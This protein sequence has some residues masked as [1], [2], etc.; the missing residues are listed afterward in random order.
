V[1]IK[2]SF[3]KNKD[4]IR[5]IFLFTYPKFVFRKTDELPLGN[6]P[7]F[8]F[9]YLAPEKFEMQLRYLF[10]NN[11]K[12]IN[13]ETLARILS[14]K[15]KPIE[16]AIVLTFDDGLKSLWTIAYP[17]LK[18]YEFTG[19]SYIIP[20][21]INNHQYFE[22]T[23][24]NV[25]SLNKNRD[26]SLCAW[27]EIIKMHESGVIDFQSHS[28]THGT[29]FIND[30]IVDFINPSFQPNFINNRFNPLL[31]NDSDVTSINVKWGLPIYK[32]ESNLAAEK[33]YIENN[34]VQQICTQFVKGNGGESFFSKP[35]WRKQ[36]IKVYKSA[37]S[38]F[39]KEKY[40]QSSKE[41]LEDIVNELSISKKEIE[42]KLN[43]RVEHLCFPWYRASVMT[44]NMA[45]EV[46]YKSSCWG[47]VKNESI[48]KVGDN[49]FFIKRINNNFIFSLPGKERKAIVNILGKK[50]LGR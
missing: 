7:I 45:K 37:K 30:K 2:E 14:G 20:S 16:R 19:I 29:V 5:G 23:A 36:L 41:R 39:E 24:V 3:V 28:L 4:D 42:L 9:H 44:V 46:G 13:A 34:D 27:D 21:L 10:Q 49:L 40:Y 48:N 26:S 6:I 25:S 11:Y 1:N 8:N 50:Y 15:I 47:I 35:G 17:L 31:F 18:K 12:T 38:N 22:N 33:R 43:K 32:S